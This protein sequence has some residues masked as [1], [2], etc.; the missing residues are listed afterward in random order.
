VTTALDLQRRGLRFFHDQDGNLRVV[1]P[2]ALIAEAIVESDKRIDIA[3]DI[4]VCAAET[5]VPP[6]GGYGICEI[7]SDGTENY[8]SGTCWLCVRAVRK[9]VEAKKSKICFLD[10]ET[11][12]LMPAARY[13][14]VQ[15]AGIICELDSLKEL[16]RFNL[17][18]APHPRDELS[19]M[20]LSVSGRSVAM[21][22]TYEPP[23][24]VHNQL[25]GIFGKHVNKYSR[26]NKM[27]FSG[28]KTSFDREHMKAWLS[29]ANA[30]SILVGS[31]FYNWFHTEEIDVF[32]FAKK[33]LADAGMVNFKLPTVCAKLGVPLETAHDAFCDIMATKG[34]YEKCR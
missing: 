29:K 1:G 7:C 22:R 17:T 27:Y 2:D 9:L 34:V 14:V 4:G 13:A 26:G 33:K 3:F 19:P 32:E 15:I 18:C 11:S 8:K 31:P 20:A 25:V 6:H 12:G 5:Y 23:H 21:V 30:G 28:Y 10:T 16:D 24:A